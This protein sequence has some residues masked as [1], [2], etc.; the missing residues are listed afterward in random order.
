MP[1]EMKAWGQITKRII[2]ELLHRCVREPCRRHMDRRCPQRSDQYSQSKQKETA[3][4]RGWWCDGATGPLLLLCMYLPAVLFA[5][6]RTTWLFWRIWHYISSNC[7]YL[8][9][10]RYGKWNLEQQ[11][12]SAIVLLLCMKKKRM[13]NFQWHI[14]TIRPLQA[15]M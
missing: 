13:N 9:D 5:G 14:I 7:V 4:A 6:S 10:Q 11:N 3:Q 12:S 8:T 1:L 2:V 15:R